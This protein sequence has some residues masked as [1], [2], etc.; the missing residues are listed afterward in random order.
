MN[1]KSSGILSFSLLATTG[2][3]LAQDATQ[4]E[5]IVVTAASYE[6]SLREAP[7]SISV[8]NENDLRSR[9]VTDVLQAVRETQGI[10][11][12]PTGGGSN[13]SSVSI[14]GMGR[15]Y[16]LML[17]NGRRISA[18]DEVIQHSDFRFD[19]V[20]MEMIE[21]VEI[22]R[23]PMSSLYGSEAFGGVVN[24]I[25]K[26]AAERWYGEV[27][28]QQGGLPGESG[29]EEFNASA[30]AAG[31]VSDTLSLTLGG[32][33][34]SRK[35]LSYPGDNRTPALTLREGK[36]GSNLILGSS[37]RPSQQHRFDVDYYRTEEDRSSYRLDTVTG[38]E[39]I[40]KLNGDVTREHSALSYYGDYGRV[41]SYLSVYR[42]EVTSLSEPADPRVPPSSSP[43][44][45]Q[46]NDAVDGRLNVELG[47]RHMVSLG[48]EALTQYH[49]HTS[50]KGGEAKADML[51]LYA[52][53]QVSLS[54]ELKLTLGLRSDRH[55]TFGSELSPRAYLVYLP[56]D[57]LTIRAGYGHGF[58]APHL[59]Y[60]TPGYESG[61][62]GYDLAANPD[63]LPEVVDGY[64]LGFDYS[65]GA[66][67]FNA[68]V[69]NNELDN[70]LVSEELKAPVRVR[71]QV[72][73][74]GLTRRIN[75]DKARITGAELMF[76]AALGYGF[77]V[78]INHTWLDTEN[79]STGDQLTDRPD[80]SSNVRL[81]WEGGDGW[82]AQ[83][84]GN[85]VG[86]QFLLVGRG[87]AAV[88]TPLPRYALYNFSLGKAITRNTTVRAGVDNL[89][90]TNLLD[91]S[92]LFTFAERGRYVF[93]S[94]ETRFN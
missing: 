47:A 8:I 10:T 93:M 74:N 7:A 67:R 5:E 83:L 12:D 35:D 33:H 73:E 9:N 57:N 51:S 11:L 43:T 55:D 48:V 60:T 13:R 65:Y 29:G 78:S 52:Q 69:F 4:V 26:P 85:F 3:A 34:F 22:V 61:R 76:T 90:D 32:G 37:F 70:L 81:G 36:R 17:L 53:D 38:A 63:L 84:R 62:P 42:S 64:E 20:P 2:L 58:K 49:I 54:D 19:W 59:K 91:E 66:Y 50:F 25:T 94:L 82:S 40:Y 86:E 31:P 92:E 75:V 88:M 21:R 15:D 44:Q 6:Q 46:R 89:A 79:K 45:G 80:H 1:K 68:I 56:S 41:N 24:V 27:R 14:R 39:I 18:S 23:G 87:T 28:A 16:S 71:G 77:D 30:V 72:V